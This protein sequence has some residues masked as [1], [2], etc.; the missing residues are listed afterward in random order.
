MKPVIIFKNVNKYYHDFH[1]LKNINLS[2]YEGEVLCII[3][4]SGSGK[5]TLIRCINNLE[6]YDNFGE[7][8]VNKSIVRKDRH[9][10]EIRK[11]VGMV[12]QS[13][14]LFPHLTVLDNVALAPIRV[15]DLSRK[16]AKLL[17]K[18][19]LNK[20][21]VGDQIDK[22]PNQLSGG[23][24]QR[25]AIARTLA[26]QPSILLFDEPTSSLDPEMV[27]E[28][29]DVIKNLAD[30]GVTMIIVTHEMNFARNV[31]DK[32]VFM[33]NGCIIEEGD[34][35]QIFDNSREKRTQSFL[36]SILN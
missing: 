21:G 34:P 2:V 32:I 8:I 19:F 29:L 27:S 30:T 28:V 17:A 16:K 1:A 5:S 24:Q 14:N 25:V 12:F 18:S 33:D 10:K 35:A 4:P 15:S 20:V 36:N 9:L 3:G 13:F 26:M 31:A 6:D 11:D 7:I 22:F 23:Q